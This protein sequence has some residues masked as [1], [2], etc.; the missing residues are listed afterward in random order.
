MFQR[1][2]RRD[3]THHLHMPEAIL[4]VRAYDYK[5]VTTVFANIYGIARRVD[6]HTTIVPVMRVLRNG[7]F[8][9]VTNREF[10][11][12]CFAVDLEQGRLNRANWTKCF[13]ERFEYLNYLFS[14]ILR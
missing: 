11:E 14:Y 2:S 7:L 9:N 1:E 10:V 12:C 4:E 8:G 3:V 6:L 13:D 5:Q